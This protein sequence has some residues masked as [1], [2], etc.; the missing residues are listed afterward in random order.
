MKKILCFLLILPGLILTARSDEGMWLPIL[1]KSIE[2]DM[3]KNGFKLTAE[4]IY[5]VNKSSMKD[6]VVLFGGGC[7]GELISN[8]GLMLT[9]HHCGFGQIQ[10]HSTV[11]KD[12]LTEGFWAMNK[13]EELQN[14]GLSVTFIIRME[15]VTQKVL[16]GIKDKLTETERA[17]MIKANIAKVS[18]ELSKES[19]QS[20]AIRPFYN[21]NE[22]YA[23]VTETYKDVRLVGAPPQSIG[24]FGGDT[25]NWVWPRHNAD[26]CIFRIYSGPDGKPAEYS[27]N[28][29]PYKP[30]YFFPV[31]MKGV[32]EDDFTMVYGFPGRTQ[33]YIS[34][35]AVDFTMNYED[36]TRIKIRDARL[37][38]MLEDMRKNDTIRIQ[39]ASKY[40]GVANGW[41]KWKGEVKGL[42]KTNALE[43]KKIYESDFKKRVGM[44]GKKEG[45]IL[46][47]LGEIYQ[48]Y[49]PLKAEEVYFSEVYNGI[50]HLALANKTAA[51]LTIPDE[52]LLKAEALKLI[53][54]AEGF[55][56][57]YTASVD[58]KIMAALLKIYAEDLG[59]N[60]L[61]PYLLTLKKQYNNNWQEFADA[62]FKTSVFTDF[63]R[64]KAAMEN[65][66]L[67]TLSADPAIL[68]ANGMSLWYN[69]EIL[70][71]VGRMI[72]SIDSLNRL[73]MTAQR[74][75]MTEKKFYPDANST[76]R[77]TYG[78]VEGFSPDDGITYSAFTTLDGLFEKNMAQPENPDYTYNKKLHT[79][80]I[81]KDYGKYAA[82]DGKIHTCFIASNHTSGG[83]SGSPVLNDKGEL[84]GI[85]FDRCWEGTM[86]D[87]NY[88]VSLCRNISADIRFV[89]FVVDKVAG[90]GYLLN[91]MKLI[92]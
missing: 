9:N 2:G 67:K 47:K 48:K 24:N 3:Q 70:P 59:E 57:N 11:E 68:L 76:L 7:T 81:K 25:D 35:Y 39:Y 72:T 75:Y 60:R 78:R 83:N 10:S 62:Y 17:D 34:S 54:G 28:N 20:V 89:L 19:Y 5:S 85:N 58:H 74:T 16:S 44:K 6:A 41:K 52:A 86:S 49:T 46:T 4:D 18:G 12:Y 40:A 79:L 53:P 8:E 43:K 77:V 88:D 56:K 26:F 92:K 27:E 63:G 84:I 30:K 21:G 13:K 90:A 50:E 87:I 23:F 38:L 36:P 51:L 42:K 66:N 55:F 61:P 45:E 31:S 1:L 37:G 69:S 71:P 15:D 91:E 80:Y 22:F 33:E 14:P 29:I 73:Y 64:F 82:K 65:P 32:D